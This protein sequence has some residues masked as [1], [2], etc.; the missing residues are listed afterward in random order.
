MPGRKTGSSSTASWHPTA[1]PNY[2]HSYYRR[3]PTTG[4][5]YNTRLRLEDNI[6]GTLRLSLDPTGHSFVTTMVTD[7][8]NVWLLKGLQRR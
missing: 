3:E 2:G 6:N 8:S 5:T 1:V 4:A 7:R